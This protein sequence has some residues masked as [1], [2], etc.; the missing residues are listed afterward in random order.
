[1]LYFKHSELV[2]KYHV[3]LKT[4]HNWIDAAK[5]GKLELIL[6]EQGK[7][8]YI[9]DTPANSRVLKGLADQG[10]KYRNVRFHKVVHPSPEFYELFNRRQILDIIS[11][12]TIHR[13]IPR[14]YNYFDGGA[15]NWSA[16]QTRLS[17]ETEP[18]N[19]NNTL[20]LL[21]T[22]MH[23]IDLLL[24]GRAKIN[25]L[26]V[27]LGNAMPSRELVAHLIEQGKLNRYIAIDISQSMLDIAE[28]NLR[29]WFGEDFP[30]EGYV[31]DITYERF[32]DLVVDDMLG[33][34]ADQTLNLVLLLG[35][36]PANFRSYNDALKVV[37]GSMGEGD[38]LI[39][40]G[41]PDSEESRRYFVVNDEEDN[42][43][44]SPN[45]SFMLDMLNIDQDLY[46]VDM[47]YDSAKRM[48][49][50]RVRMR[51]SIS[52]QFRHKDISRNVDIE[53]GETILMLR[54]WHMSV[55]ET[56]TRFEDV[57]FVMLQSNM[58][59]NYGRMLIICGIDTKSENADLI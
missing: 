50:I 48:R 14:Q 20:T 29:S 32:D 24:E 47:G 15:T 2:N 34:D 44:L 26:D 18:N 54:V 45:Y 53:K 8:S 36:T 23:A 11:N 9:A 40:T 57:G 35:A 12:L 58:P 17:K 30:Y 19:L 28:Q 7:R 49:Y 31:R 27:G 55:L 43:K 42:T 6:F 56:V 39:Y 25:V 33:S 51:Q 38:V 3:S 41:K 59:K 1:M 4:V 16:L 22:N 5:Q 13:E 21:R 52:V 10:K 46:D 37:Y